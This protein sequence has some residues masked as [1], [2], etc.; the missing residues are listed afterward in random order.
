MSSGD[1]SSESRDLWIWYF[2]NAQLDESRLELAVSGKIV[3][4]ERKPLELLLCLLQHSGEVV[5]KEELNAELW[6]GRP[7]V[8]ATLTTCVK[9][10]RE[11]LGDDTRAVIKTVHGFGYRLSVP[12][13]RDR[14]RDGIAATPAS[15]D[16]AFIH[17]LRPQMRLISRYPF[18]RGENWLV[19]NI[20]TRDRRA[21]KFAL[22]SAQLAQLK[23]EVT[24]HR[25][26]SSTLGKT[27]AF[28]KLIAW[29]FEV[30]PYFAEFEHYD[31]GNLE[32][33]LS[34]QGGAKAVGIDVRLELVAQIA[35]AL[36]LAHAAG[37]LHKDVKP[38]NVLMQTVDGAQKACLADFGS[39]RILNSDRL[40]AL[41]IT[42]LG[43]TLNVASSDEGSGTW[44]Y[45]APEVVAGQP[46]TA[47]SDIFALGVLLYG[48]VLGELGRPL[49]PGWE[50]EVSDE[51][52]REDVAACCDVDPVHRLGD[53][54]DLSRRL[55]SLP[56]RRSDRLAE[57]AKSEHERSL[58]AALAYSR[59]RRRW[60]A[61][62]AGLACIGL[63]VIVPLYY[64]VGRA[65]SA[66]QQQA[67]ASQAINE[68]LVD[69]LISALNPVSRT[70]PDTLESAGIGAP[71][72]VRQLLD[73]AAQGAASRFKGQPGLESRVRMSL[74]D[75]YFGLAAYHEAAEQFNV[76]HEKLQVVATKDDLLD[77][78]ALFRAGVAFLEA[79]DFLRAEDL[80]Q[81]TRAILP[82][83]MEDDGGRRLAIQVDEASGWLS[84]KLGDYDRALQQMQ[85]ALPGIKKWFGEASEETATTLV[86]IANTH[87]VARH[88]NDAV[89][90]AR[91]AL[92]LRVDLDGPNHPV[93]IRAH[94]LLA[95]ALR[96]AGSLDQ[97]EREAREAFQMSEKVLGQDHADTLLA[98]VSLASVIQQQGRNDEAIH[99]FE[100]GY[101]RS[102]KRYGEA[103]TDTT[104]FLNNLAIAYGDAGHTEQAVQSMERAIVNARQI[105]G[106]D[107]PD[108]ISK[109]HNLADLLADANRWKEARTL[110]ERVLP[111]AKKAWGSDN[112]SVGYV[113]KTLAR[114]YLHFAEWE[115]ADAALADAESVLAAQND[116]TNPLFS[117]VGAVKEELAKL[118]K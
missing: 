7:V 5:T 112:I 76:A 17:A 116:P 79:D 49:A 101:T 10:L 13:R 108:V 41:E 65:R 59:T 99:L 45:L 48:L 19:E 64:Q 46:P 117:R 34:A 42:R 54:L 33:W 31:L 114:I 78:R 82:R 110:E 8:E 115:K 103:S 105:F 38:S 61:A 109:E 15:L 68:Y 89:D 81:R 83:I 60:L 69:D 67:A 84:Y 92:A 2:A 39:G 24:V 95:E 43:F 9:K 104:A 107:H 14:V 97:A 66:A 35:D 111:R 91:A 73:R 18:S 98:E 87:I 90:S 12:I 44:I 74:G 40:M 52:L 113:D 63:A 57:Q 37:V 58:V 86:H 56:K 36:A 80:F 72:P 94:V 77:G 22:D 4:V 102:A 29:N 32:Q 93:V 47:R 106:P 21:F 71:V 23:R 6:Q 20:K 88:T 25:L 96:M 3:P 100:D 55:R 27:E 16:T 1:A 85:A 26:L 51:L 30:I 62:I 75:A 53:A 70:A 118:R 28:A 50:R 11:A